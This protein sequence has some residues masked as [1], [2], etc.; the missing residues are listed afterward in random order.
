MEENGIISP[1][2][3]NASI[4]SPSRN[5]QKLRKTATQINDTDMHNMYSPDSKKR[6]TLR[7]LSSKILSSVSSF[8]N[9]SDKSCIT[10]LS[11][12]KSTALNVVA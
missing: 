5:A 8:L 11:E 12:R 9:W 3:N 7:L 10:F 6:K 2:L 4:S 1:H